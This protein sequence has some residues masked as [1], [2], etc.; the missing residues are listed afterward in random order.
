M[1]NAARASHDAS[2]R[3]DIVQCDNEILWLQPRLA[4]NLTSHK[5]GLAP[6]PLRRLGAS[7]SVS[8]ALNLSM[9]GIAFAPSAQALEDDAPPAPVVEVLPQSAE[10]PET[11]DFEAA[12]VTLV[13]EADETAESSGATATA[14]R[15]TSLECDESEI[16]AMHR[17]D[18]RR[19]IA[20]GLRGPNEPIE[21]GG[22]KISRRLV[23]AILRASE[24]TGVDPVYMMALA[25]KESS[26]SVD[27]KASTSSAEG[28]FQFI[29]RTWLD[30]VREFGPRHG[31]HAEAAAIEVVEGDPR[32]ADELMR[33]RILGLRRDPYFS[34]VMAAELLKKDRASIEQRIGRELRQTEF[35]LTHFFGVDA[36]GRFMKLLDDKPKQSA[37]RVFPQAAK[38]NKPLFFARKGKKTKD[39]SVAE[40]YA[41][42]D[43]MIDRRIGRYRAVTTIAL[44]PSL[45]PSS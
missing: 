45:Q 14:G 6:R 4:A 44:P 17:N 8:I 43:R 29:A 35:Y 7:L 13:S 21:F 24:T 19:L 38:A 41:K 22:V 30:A 18:V 10:A 15:G 2:S 40:V 39:L 37:P 42:I 9:A 1:H 36:A 25:D 12:P 11:T 34:A 31:L 27:V 5:G 16:A 20:A 33:E 32:V 26:F 23:E 3:M 28:L